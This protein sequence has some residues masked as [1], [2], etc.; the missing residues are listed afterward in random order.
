MSRSGLKSIEKKY[1]SNLRT[2]ESTPYLAHTEYNYDEED[3]ARAYYEA[4]Q[5]RIAEQE[6]QRREQASIAAQQRYEDTHADRLLTQAEQSP[7]SYISDAEMPV[8]DLN[9]HDRATATT[10]QRYQKAL[11]DLTEKP[12]RASM[13]PNSRQA[14]EIADAERG[15]KAM[16]ERWARAGQDPARLASAG[17]SM[18]AIAQEKYKAYNPS[19]ANNA[20]NKAQREYY[21]NLYN[22]SGDLAGDIAPNEGAIAS[23]FVNNDKDRKVRTQNEELVYAEDKIASLSKKERD[24]LTYYLS[25]YQAETGLDGLQTAAGMSKK[26]GEAYFKQ[27]GGGDGKTTFDQ[28]IQY[29]RELSDYNKTAQQKKFSY[30]ATHVGKDASLGEKVAANAYKV[31]S[32]ARDVVLSPFQGI[33]GTV[34]DFYNRAHGYADKAAPTNTY[35]NMFALQNLNNI[36]KEAV[37]DTIDSKLGKTLYDF[38]MNAGENISRSLWAGGLMQGASPAVMS[39]ASLAAMTPNVYA[40][41]VQNAQQRGVTGWNTAFTAA[42]D[43]AWEVITEKL[44][45]D[46]YF[47]VSQGSKATYKEL[48]KSGL[49]EMGMEG[50][51][52]MISEVTDSIFDYQ[53]NG[54]KSEMGQSILAYQQDGMTE[55][56]AKR[57]AALDLM[58][59]T[60]KAGISG[61]ALGGMMGGIGAVQNIANTRAERNFARSAYGGVDGAEN[62]RSTAD[63]IDPADYSSA[64]AADRAKTAQEIFY[65]ELDKVENGKKGD[66]IQQGRAFRMM[67]E[68]EAIQTEAD[69]TAAAQKEKTFQKNAKELRENNAG[70]I[71]QNTDVKHSQ[72]QDM[73]TGELKTAEGFVKADNGA[74][75][76]QT[77]S[78]TVSVDNVDFGNSAKQELFSGLSKMKDANAANIG[79]NLYQAGENTARYLMGFDK[80]YS[81]GRWAAD[82]GNSSEESF[83][84]FAAHNMQMVNYFGEERLK[85]FY[86]AGVQTM[87]SDMQAAAFRNASTAISHKGTG[88]FTDAR[89]DR[90]QT[91]PLKGIKAVAAMTGV[92]IEIADIGFEQ[93]ENGSFDASTGKLRLNT[94]SGK[95]AQTLFHELGEF[96]DSFNSAEW[97]DYT[98]SVMNVA[99]EVMGDEAFNEAR[100]K[101]VKAYAGE[102]N[103]TEADI[104]KE[105]A[106]DVSYMLFG[107]EDGFTQ[108][109]IEIEKNSGAEK[110]R[111]TIQKIV[112]FFDKVI[113]SINSLIGKTDESRLNNYQREMQKH[114]D[115]LEALREQA[116]KAIGKATGN[117]EQV[118]VGKD[119]NV[120]T[121][122]VRHSYDESMDDKLKKFIDRS[123]DASV[124][125]PAAAY[126]TIEKHVNSELAEGLSEIY[127]IDFSDYENVIDRNAIIHIAYRHGEHGVADQSM[128][129]TEDLARIKYVLDNYDKAWDTKE[130]SGNV[131]NADNSYAP[132]VLIQKE[133]D[134]GF[135]YVA[136]AVPDSKKKRLVVQS[137]YINKTDQSIGELNAV[138]PKHNVQNETPL[139][140]QSVVDSNVQQQS[141][142]SKRFS[143]DTDV[144][145]G[146]TLIAVH[147]LSADK[148]RKSLALGGFPMPSL[149][150]TKA[151]IHH[152]NFG[153][154]SF[155]FGKETID[156]KLDK[157][158]NVYSADAWTPVVPRTEY[159]GNGK[160]ITEVNKRLNNLSTRVDD[161]FRSDIMNGL[162]DTYSLNSRGGE[163]GYVDTMRDNTGMKAAYLE[164]Q[165]HHIDRITKEVEK[166]DEIGFNRQKVEEYQAIADLLSD[167]ADGENL[168]TLALSDVMDQFGE[169]IEQ[170]YPGVTKNAFRLRSALRA[171]QNWLESDGTEPT[172]RYETITDTEAMRKAVNSAVDQE[173]YEAWLKDLYSDIEGS[174]GVYNNKDLFTPSGNRRSFAQTHFPATL[175]GIVKAM[176]SQN[177]GNSVNVEQNFYGAKTLRANTAKRFKSIADMHDME[178]RLQE[179]TSEQQEKLQHDFDDRVSNIITDVLEQREYKSSSADWSQREN[180]GQILAEAAELKNISVGNIQKVFAQYSYK[181]TDETAADI[182]QLLFD[183][184]QMP[185]NMFE[186]KPAR[187]VLFTEAKAAI[188]PEGT[189]QDLVDQLKGYGI[190][191]LEYKKGDNEERLAKINS[192]PDVRFSR[193]VEDSLESKPVDDFSLWDQLFDT[194]YGADAESTVSILEKGEAALKDAKIDAKFAQ[195]VAT[196]VLHYYGSQYD[197]ATLEGN[198]NKLYALVQKGDVN[199]DDLMDIASEIAMPVIEASNQKV[200]TEEYNSLIRSLARYKIAL[201]DTQMAEAKSAFGSYN[202]FK[203]AMHGVNISKNGTTLDSIWSE[204]V[205][206]TGGVLE[207]DTAEGDMP[208]ALYDAIQT[209]RPSMKNNFE[210]TQEEVANDM[211]LDL[212]TRMYEEVGR[213]EGHK[214]A[215]KVADRLKEQRKAYQ[216]RVRD[217][218][219]AKLSEERANMK[220]RVAGIREDRAQ[221]IAEL[222]ARNRNQMQKV[223]ENRKKQYQIKQLQKRVGNLYDELAKPTDT[224]HVP[225][226]LRGSVLSFLD[227]VDMANP[228]IRQ[229]ADGNFRVRILDHMDESGKLIFDTQDF[230]T[231]KQAREAYDTAITNGKGSIANQKWAQMMQGVKELY[232]QA[233]GERA[234]STMNGDFIQ[235][236]DESLSDQ[237]TDILGKSGGVAS[238]TELSS[239]EL[240]TLNRVAINIQ[241][242]VTN[243][244]KLITSPSVEVTSI[245]DGIKAHAKSVKGRQAHSGM[246]NRLADFFS[247]SMATPDTYFHGL[248]KSGERV[249]DILLDAQDVKNADIRNIQSYMEDVMKD[250][251]ENEVRTWSGDKAKVYSFPKQNVRM[252]KAQIMSLYELSKRPQAMAHMVGGVKIDTINENGKQINQKAQHLTVADIAEITGTLT[253]REKAIADK[254]Q[255]YMATESARIGNEAS[256]QMFGYKKFDEG[257]SYYPIWTDKSTIATKSMQ[258][259]NNVGNSIRNMGFTKQLVQDASNPIV[260]GDIFQT[261]V[262]HTTDMATYHAYAARMTD[263]LRILNS[264]TTEDVG[265]GFLEW[266]GVKNAVEDVY[267]KGGV[268]YWERLINDINGQ[269]QSRYEGNPIELFVSSA[270]KASAVTGNIR[271]V[272]QQPM[273]YT[274]AMNMIDG[275]YMRRGFVKNAESDKAF[276]NN[277]LAWAKSQ[278]NIDGFITS[279][280]TKQVTGI[281]TNREKLMEIMGAGAGA[282]D[283]F[284]WKRLYR[285]VWAEQADIAKAKGMQVSADNQAFV[286]MVDDRFR[287]MVSSTQVMDSTLFRSQFMRSPDKM[288]VFQASF[289]AEPIKSY[290]LFLQA[291]MDVQQGRKGAKRQFARTAAV[292]TF[293]NFLMA[294]AQTAV[295]WGMRGDPDKDPKEEALE[296]WW[297]NF[298]G[299]MDP[300]QM[301]PVVK[302]F[303]SAIMDNIFGKSNYGSNG[304][305]YYIQALQNGA[306]AVNDTVKFIKGEGSKTGYGVVK[307]NARAL[308]QLSGIPV[309]NVMRDA[310]GAWNRFSGTIFPVVTGKESGPVL[311]DTISKEKNHAKLM[312]LDAIERGKDPKEYMDAWVKAGQNPEKLI[313]QLGNVYKKEYQEMLVSDPEG[314]AELAKQLAPALE[315]ADS[316]S[317]QSKTA[318]DGKPRVSRTGEEILAGWNAKSEANAEA[319]KAV[320]G[321]LDNALINGEGGAPQIKSSMEEYV[322]GMKPATLE[323]QKKI[324]A[325]FNDGFTDRYKATYTNLYKTDKKAAAS[326]RTR[327]VEALFSIT[328]S[329]GVYT[330]VTDDQR[331]KKIEDRIDKWVAENQ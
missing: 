222:K 119:N 213:Q 331:R 77:D 235:L 219:Q 215:Q 311:L 135:Y 197:R 182:K 89:V 95:V 236:L 178:W 202:N 49:K 261:F 302:D 40:Q 266:D 1:L 297:D 107:N 233:N 25:H 57:K 217:R 155:V 12:T 322:S 146:N 158:N 127:G 208:A 144:E 151:D 320:W 313:E 51:Q 258:S 177:G 274:R 11:N 113:D 83:N 206:L 318:E 282:A 111:T 42:N 295:D 246:G 93:G 10:Y 154:I 24:A 46:E 314:A 88:T 59:D 296:M 5:A 9:A 44:P 301:V 257:G 6:R 173:G 229:T 321:T 43:A 50:A 134:D 160:R 290:N 285:A 326:M 292:Y 41:S 168:T 23:S 153:D 293:T 69:Q 22:N 264:K 84:N 277:S 97:Q 262:Q 109:L 255:Q 179:L 250:I 133:I 156:P 141:R 120:T 228:N 249:Y 188:I 265:N 33:S 308:S 108:L 305:A 216:K 20:Y 85:Q 100:Q 101:Y 118:Q 286:K 330:D 180:A 121:S 34:E 226:S 289:M 28:Y 315:Y 186:A 283:D 184:S 169:R 78:G 276:A 54:D 8:A 159:E 99:R 53:L 232:A 316:L 142:N 86:D 225:E 75:V 245:A 138:S 123:M 3:K 189:D 324:Y 209:M 191:V 329:A 116:A 240:Q 27:A 4:A 82:N 165:G 80:F 273:S 52:E 278:G 139:R 14:K 256:M 39:N 267:G 62:L 218:Y 272:V 227:A 13:N 30:D 207:Y 204:M 152:T 247:L 70:P 287:K 122:D 125:M 91:L 60:V 148:L 210:G 243:E 231:Y 263:V 157:K 114:V 163:Q 79:L 239:S 241:K 174:S 65:R 67:E 2:P 31:Y 26:D 221:Q 115:Q 214:E 325:S 136:E 281:A 230:D 147:N 45:L 128:A 56:E 309:Y 76:V 17:A 242:A 98:K 81:Q 90:S 192:I 234:S 7:L 193:D 300:L 299:N 254:M 198:L 71:D 149:A 55:A 201:T 317:Q 310:V 66:P 47:K 171:T 112:D 270:Y 18:D 105:M 48:V 280:M 166:K 104:D 19:T 298:K 63:A 175:D 200:G 72:M 164:E 130:K 185:V 187:A 203:R 68:A 312:T 294:F 126:F 36:D 87:R 304:G 307:S 61:A 58:G 162:A 194:Y 224:R 140:N 238:V 183:I 172:A 223:S 195:R 275:K 319:K 244:N 248:G 181:L 328:K 106:N 212:V 205:D 96:A 170:I 161:A 29:Y 269:E 220:E 211:A 253:E 131:R 237:L 38:G 167:F 291:V 268:M 103:K 190:R 150:I 323:E 288:N 37:S 21:D 252:T 251:P 260:V 327:M 73:Q 145:E 92:D 303:E 271:V 124:K 15:V 284:T 64:E 110:S 143:M 132:I 196:D 306:M 74:V 176:A 102:V 32:S 35:S 279:S 94:N 16:Q 199:Y 259:A 129:N 137:A 117:Y